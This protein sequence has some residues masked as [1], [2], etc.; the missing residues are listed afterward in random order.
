MRFYGY[1]HKMFWN[2][3]N[4]A[5]IEIRIR[6]LVEHVPWSQFRRL[7]GPFTNSLLQL[8]TVD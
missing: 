1:E 6:L 7:V 4:F 5:S 3:Q 2:F 8:G